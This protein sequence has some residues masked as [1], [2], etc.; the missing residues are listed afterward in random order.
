MILFRGKYIYN[1]EWIVGDVHK[2]TDS[3]K[4][5]IHPI[6]ERVRSFDVIPYTVGQYINRDDKNGQ[7]IFTGDI[8]KAKVHHRTGYKNVIG[9]VVFDISELRF[10]LVTELETFPCKIIPDS[11]H[12]EII[13]NIFDN[14]ELLGNNPLNNKLRC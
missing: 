3:T 7:K 9:V 10:G 14:S 5:H 12:C 2:N 4:V 1:G 13:G 11:K 6:G 8:I